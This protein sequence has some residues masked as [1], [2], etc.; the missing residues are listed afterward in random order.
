M[1][2]KTIQTSKN[3]AKIING[4]ISLS[5]N[6]TVYKINKYKIYENRMVY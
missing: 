6:R 2:P 1:K 5:C 4:K 3:N